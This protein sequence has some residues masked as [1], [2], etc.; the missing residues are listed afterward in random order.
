M[1]NTNDHTIF[2]WADGSYL[3]DSLL[4][5]NPA[6]FNGSG[7]IV[8]TKNLAASPFSLTNK[9]LNL[10]LLIKTFQ[11]SKLCLAVLD[12]Q[13]KGWDMKYLGIYLERQS[14]IADV[15][16]RVWSNELVKIDVAD[17]SE[18]QREAIYVK[19]ERTFSISPRCY[20]YEIAAMELEE[21]GIYPRHIAD[22]TK[23]MG[24]IPAIKN[25][26]HVLQFTDESGD[27]FGVLLKP[28][29][30]SHIPFR[31]GPRLLADVVD[32]TKF[33]INPLKFGFLEIDVEKPN[34][35]GI[36]HGVNSSPVI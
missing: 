5:T 23:S 15:F 21:S 17:I 36:D 22:D 18:L 29:L 30:S 24:I 10:N 26:A 14:D 35:A 32:L 20:G 31:G 12:C 27:G 2:A 4:A 34:Y 13:D 16:K 19:Q 28:S 1:R 6:F 25:Q 3:S 8:Q 11:K 9:G 33:D 7:N